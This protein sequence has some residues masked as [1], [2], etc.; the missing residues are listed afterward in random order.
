[1]IEVKRYGHFLP[2][3]VIKLDVYDAQELADVIK[4]AV[5]QVGYPPSVKKR[6][7]KLTNDL[8]RCIEEE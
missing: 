4:D 1:M 2:D 7:D 6:L 3:I 5:L 8:F